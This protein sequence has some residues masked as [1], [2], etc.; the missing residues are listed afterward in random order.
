M[1][2]EQP[3]INYPELK[4]VFNPNENC[5]GCG[6]ILG[7]KLLLQFVGPCALVSSDNISHLFSNSLKVPLVSLGSNPAAVASGLKVNVPVVV[8]S[9]KQSALTHL[10]SILNVISRNDNMIFV[11]VNNG[12]VFDS[13][14]KQVCN[15]PYVATCSVSYPEDMAVKI[16]KSLIIQGFRFIEI[17]APCPEKLGYEKSNTVEIGRLGTETSYWPLFEIENKKLS[18]TK[19]PLR[20]EPVEKFLSATKNS[21]NLD[22][23]ERINKN[24]KSLSEGKIF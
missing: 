15:A 2:E 12:I 13:L 20:I 23:Q 14:A 9:D 1:N 11:C 24:W 8:Y 7:L 6:T 18:I 22:L 19:R 21:K 5:P 3:I 4:Q 10:S 17:F 16:K